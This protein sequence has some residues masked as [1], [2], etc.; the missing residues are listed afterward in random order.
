LPP[1]TRIIIRGYEDGYNDILLLIPMIIIPHPEQKAGYYG[2]YARSRDEE[3]KTGAISAVE[4]YGEN[5]K[6]ER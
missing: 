5:T 6:A 3:K 2:E 1:D 4:L